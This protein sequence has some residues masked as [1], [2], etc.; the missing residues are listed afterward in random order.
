MPKVPIPIPSGD[1]G[2]DLFE[3]LQRKLLR[4]YGA[5]GLYEDLI[6]VMYLIYRRAIMDFDPDRGV[7]MT[8]FIV[9]RLTTDTYSWARS[10]WRYRNR[11]VAWDLQGHDI[12]SDDAKNYP[13][14][15][16]VIKLILEEA[17]AGLP[18]ALA[19]LSKRQRLAVT[20]RFLKEQPYDVVAAMLDCKEATARS[21]VRHG[22][23]TLRKVLPNQM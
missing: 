8:A 13:L 6:G 10:E 21:I 9:K 15:E 18:N 14:D 5:G 7:P 23:N 12:V 11:I 19:Q 2:Y 3:P 20:E 16:W 4:I 17:I 1:P 22:M